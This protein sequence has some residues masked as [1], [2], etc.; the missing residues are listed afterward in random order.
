MVKIKPLAGLGWF[1]DR[2]K[3]VFYVGALVDFELLAVFSRPIARL[4]GQFA[5]G[6]F[7]RWGLLVAAAKAFTLRSG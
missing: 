3:V 1:E 7:F 6:A 2:L 5:R 4:D